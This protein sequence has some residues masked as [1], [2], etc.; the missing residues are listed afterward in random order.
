MANHKVYINHGIRMANLVA[1]LRMAS[2]GPVPGMARNGQLKS[3]YNFKNGR[4]EVCVRNM[5]R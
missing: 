4:D 1:T 5:V 2:T 3:S